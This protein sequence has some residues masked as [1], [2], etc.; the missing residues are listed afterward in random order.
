MTMSKE[1]VNHLRELVKEK[2]KLL[3]EAKREQEAK[4]LEEELKPILPPPQKSWI[5]Q[6]IS[7]INSPDFWYH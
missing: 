1:Q 6:I 5:K 2:R 3:Q 7:L 4:K